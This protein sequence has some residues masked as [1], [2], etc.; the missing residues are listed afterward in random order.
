[1]W[2][3]AAQQEEV[4]ELSVR[5][6]CSTTPCHTRDATPPPCPPPG[7]RGTAYQGAGRLHEALRDLEAAEATAEAEGEER[8]KRLIAK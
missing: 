5:L 7:R 6:C 8:S 4:V 3:G 1:M 2:T